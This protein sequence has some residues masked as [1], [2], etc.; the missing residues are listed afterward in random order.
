MQLGF[1]KDSQE[2]NEEKFYI[3]FSRKC[4]FFYMIGR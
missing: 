3:S 1:F 2:Y 4:S